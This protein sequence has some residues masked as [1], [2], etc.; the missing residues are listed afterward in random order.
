MIYT[1]SGNGRSKF[2][3]AITEALKEQKQ[4]LIS[5]RQIVVHFE[6]EKEGYLGIYEIRIN[7]IACSFTVDFKNVDP[8][9]FPARIKAAARALC[10]EGYDGT[11][12]IS[13]KAGE[14]KIRKK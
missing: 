7:P 6:S 8:T 14:L 1:F 2:M 4:L 11:Y 9:R 3:P 13:H 5:G 10:Q 12:E